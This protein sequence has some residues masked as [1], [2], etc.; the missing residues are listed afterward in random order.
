MRSIS[1]ISFLLVSMLT[2]CA[3]PLDTGPMRPTTAIIQELS[4]QEGLQRN[5]QVSNVEVPKEFNTGDVGTIDSATLK[6]VLIDTLYSAGYAV[7]D[8]LLVASSTTDNTVGAMYTFDA[9]LKELSTPAFGFDLD[10]KCVIAYKLTRIDDGQVVLDESV[11]QG[12]LATFGQAFNGV[13]RARIGQS[14]A[15]GENITQLLRILS[16]IEVEEPEPAR[17]NRRGRT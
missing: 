5:V 3:P 8:K 1:L 10:A 4:A 14:H 9:T 6:S 2:G 16:R 17:N 7:N 15:I 12:Y 13:E 11:T